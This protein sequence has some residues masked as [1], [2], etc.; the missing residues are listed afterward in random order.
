MLSD[1]PELKYNAYFGVRA[2]GIIQVD[3][4]YSSSAPLPGRRI[5]PPEPYLLPM[6]E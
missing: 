1:L 4:V 2:A 6:V 3:E 5:V